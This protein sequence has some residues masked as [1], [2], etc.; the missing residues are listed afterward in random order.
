M[1]RDELLRAGQ[2]PVRCLFCGQTGEAEQFGGRALRCRACSAVLPLPEHATTGPQ[3]PRIPH[4]PGVAPDGLLRG[5]YRLVKRLGAGAHGVSYLAEHEFLTNPCVVKVLPHRIGDV[6][7][8]AVRRL[9]NEARAG[10][11][12]HD[13]HVVRVLDCDVVSGVWYFVMEYV[14]G[15]DLGM[16]LDGRTRLPWKQVVRIAVDAARGLMAVHAADLLHRD[17]KP[18]NLILGADGRVRVAD[19]GVAGLTL[20]HRE[21]SPG[22]GAA[23][24]GTLA[25]SAPEMFQPGAEVGP[26]ADMYSLGATMYHLVT[27]EPPHTG[28]QVFRRLIDLQ[29]RPAQWPDDD[30]SVPEWLRHVIL[31]LLAIEPANRLVTPSEFLKAL[32]VPIHA[33]PAAENTQAVFDQMQPRGMGVL[34]L[35]NE[36]PT[37]EQ[38]WIG[39]AVANH[40]SR[41]LAEFPE[42][43]VADQDVLVMML[44]R[45][46]H[47]GEMSERE[48]LF[49][50]GRR[51]GAGTLVTGRYAVS[52]DTV[53]I[54]LEVIRADQPRPL[55]AVVAE[56]TLRELDQLE[57]RLL[58]Q[59]RG[60]LGL[61]PAAPRQL[62]ATVLAAREKFTLGRQAYLRG[63]YER[64]IEL[65]EAAGRLQPDFIEAI[66]FVGVCQARLGRYD[67]AEAQHRRQ[68]ALARAAGD[69]RRQIEAL[70]NLGVM[71]YFRGEYRAAEQ[72]Y[73][74]AQRLADMR[75]LPTESAQICNNL[76]F[77]LFRLD[78]LTEAEEVFVR[79][80]ATHEAYGALSSLIGP[81]NG[82]GNVF[83]EQGRYAEARAYYRHA[84][85]LATETGDRTSVGTTHTHLGH[86]AALEG[87][88]ADAKHEFTMALNALEETRFWNGL[89]RAWEYS[90]AMHL[91]LANW[92]EALR[93]TE[94]RIDLAR[95]HSN[96]RME[97]A[98]WEQHAD[99]LRRAGRQAEAAAA[100]ARG[101][102]LLAALQAASSPCPPLTS[103]GRKG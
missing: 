63:E 6:T 62:V 9:R 99:A 64:A 91:Q 21:L 60:V 48:R 85:D 89:A 23:M 83:T 14:D 100:R 73:R 37:L 80:I 59:L 98:A 86:C 5:K 67:A 52:A 47:H 61:K 90:A 79:A 8:A 87:A 45:I 69:V 26:A 82:M 28:A 1:D 88:F 84:L 46:E 34:P 12:V 50:A 41:M 31:R 72:H 96:V 25:Y 22:V 18:G 7:D 77:V 78:R 43:Y 20:D 75:A 54:V 19:L 58:D 102:G 68:E 36:R 95:Q 92:D 97:A 24:A 56:R 40:L 4:V 49:E 2:N 38:D 44:G 29:C 74:E 42:I 27:G 57:R 71:Y 65:G 66:G 51:V 3:P 32:Q 30:G 11:R 76:G 94:M 93:C 13:P 17:I 81:Y 35:Q 15:V 70:A 53:R 101:E 55:A 39:Y 103:A 33:A 10:F 16:V